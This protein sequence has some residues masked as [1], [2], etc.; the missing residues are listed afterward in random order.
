MSGHTQEEERVIDF[1]TLDFQNDVASPDA[2]WVIDFLARKLQEAMENLA[3]K[4]KIN[5]GHIKG[6]SI[7]GIERKL[8]LQQFV[9]DTNALLNNDEDSVNGFLD[10]LNDFCAANGSRINHSKTGVKAINGTLPLSVLDTGCKEIEDGKSCHQIGV[11]HRQK[12]N[13]NDRNGF[14]CH[15]NDCHLH[16]FCGKNLKA[17]VERYSVVFQHA[18]LEHLQLNH[19]CSRVAT[20]VVYNGYIC[21][22]LHHVHKNSTKWVTPIEF[23]TF[24]GGEGIYEVDLTPKGCFITYKGHKVDEVLYDTLQNKQNNADMAYEDRHGRALMH[25]MNVMIP[26][27]LTPTPS[28]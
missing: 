1:G 20:N 24:M 8:C 7:P 22:P 23:V 3:C 27:T 16:L 26:P 18:F 12:G 10:C 28:S 14:K 6:I 9:D 4:D 11:Y 5:Q 15:S 17:R 13:N 21:N 25:L 19:F 2:T